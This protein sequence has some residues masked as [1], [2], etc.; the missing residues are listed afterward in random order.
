MTRKSK[1]QSA[2]CKDDLVRLS[3]KYCQSIVV[4][5]PSEW[6][7]LK[8]NIWRRRNYAQLK[9]TVM[10][11]VLQLYLLSYCCLRETELLNYWMF[12]NLHTFCVL[13]IVKLS[14]WVFSEKWKFWTICCCD[15]LSE[16]LWSLVEWVSVGVV[17]KLYYGCG[18][19]KNMYFYK[20]FIL[21]FYAI[22]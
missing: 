19:D 13:Q 2:S 14:S 21:I 22:N 18:E 12:N 15:N 20:V 10:C 11:S 4:Q 17:I 1:A 16:S 7:L 3:S 8:R 9:H 5:H 6:T